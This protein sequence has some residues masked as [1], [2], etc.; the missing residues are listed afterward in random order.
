[1]PDVDD[2]DSV[3]DTAELPIFQQV[4]GWFR[5]EAGAEAVEWKTAADEA[6]R[7]AER[8]TTQV[9]ST[10]KTTSGLPVRIPRQH[11]VPGGVDV[12]AE[13]ETGA[14]RRDPDRVASAMAAYARG[15]ANRRPSPAATTTD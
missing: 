7:Q 10:R 11:L 2:V 1:V 14:D 4:S 5:A 8:A 15:V 13:R 12:P 6:W 3:D 9:T